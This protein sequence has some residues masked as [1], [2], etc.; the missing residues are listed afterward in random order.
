LVKAETPGRSLENTLFEALDAGSRGGATMGDLLALLSLV[1]LMGIINLI[2]GQGDPEGVSGQ[3]S[4]SSGLT[5][6]S[7][8]A[9]GQ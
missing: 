9:G 7:E 8:W 5:E 1:N 3:D 4:G 2:S 6:Y